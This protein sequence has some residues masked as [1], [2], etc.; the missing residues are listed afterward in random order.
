[1]P[2][3]HLDA[4]EDDLSDLTLHCELCGGELIPLGALGSL[5]HYRC[6]NCGMDASQTIPNPQE[7]LL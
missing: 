5:M 1:M 7:E 3:N 2:E 4:I 6:R